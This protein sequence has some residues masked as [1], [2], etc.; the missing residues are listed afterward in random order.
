MVI[1]PLSEAIIGMLAD[2]FTVSVALASVG[3]AL[4]LIFVLSLKSHQKQALASIDQQQEV[5]EVHRTSP[6]RWEARSQ[7]CS[8]HVHSAQDFKT[9]EA[10]DSDEE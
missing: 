5:F 7:E 4:I 6:F 1:I 8:S 10:T 2:Q 9:G 3:V